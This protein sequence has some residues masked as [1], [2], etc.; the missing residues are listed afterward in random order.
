[1]GCQFHHKKNTIYWIY[2]PEIHIDQAQINKVV[3]YLSLDRSRPIIFVHIS[4]PMKT[5]M[6]IINIIVEACK[7]LNHEIQYIVSEG[8]PTGNTEPK[9]LAGSGW[10]DEWC[11]VRD[12]IFAMS[13]LLII[14]GGHV[15][16]SQV[17]SLGNL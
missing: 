14:R 12:E 7:C 13:N 15:V 9:K 16:I 2:V 11:P 1:M 17:F 10:D 5:R 3:E 6:T 8:R 4:G